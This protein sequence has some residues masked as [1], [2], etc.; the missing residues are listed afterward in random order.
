VRANASAL[1]DAVM[2]L[3]LNAVD[4]MP[5]GGR[6][7]VATRPHDAGAEL[8]VEDTGEGIPEDAR[9]R[10][11]DPFF[12]TRSPQRMGLGLT[13]AHGVV[14][15]Y[16]GRIEISASP[17][18]GTRVTIRLPG[19]ETA[20]LPAVPGRAASSGRRAPEP[21]PLGPPGDVASILVLEHEAAA[22]SLLVETLGQAGHTV[23][24][25]VDGLSGLGKLERGR[26]D[27]VLADLALPERSGLA[28]A[29]AVRGL[30]PHTPVVLI[31]GW[32]HLL[33]PVRL[34]E[35]GVDLMLLKPFRV[36][37]VLSVVADALRL[38]PSS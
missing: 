15:R 10:A 1:R 28:I 29:R 13:V 17:G 34:R 36:G 33:D 24:T 37:R 30:H 35:H 26:F 16:G 19:A 5:R 31:T 22:L 14:M 18:G 32:G 25:A 8:V 7:R 20:A 4:A 21:G 27:L 2:N 9:R 3:V 6:L 38:R 12:T 11:F 23:E